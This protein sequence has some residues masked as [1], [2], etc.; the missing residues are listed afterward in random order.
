MHCEIVDGVVVINAY[1][2]TDIYALRHWAKEGKRVTWCTAKGEPDIEED[3][4]E[5]KPVKEVAA[6]PAKDEKE[7][8]NER[9]KLVKQLEDMGVKVRKGTRVTTLRDMLKNAKEGMGEAKKEAPKE[10]NGAVADEDF[11]S[12]DPKSYTKADVVEALKTVIAKHSELVAK[13]ILNGHGAKTVSELKTDK[14]AALISEC[15]AS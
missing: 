8:K 5:A 6:E 10:I 7:L 14:Y 12:V 3:M 9:A 15:E 11:L 13:N 1:S 2:P 4:T